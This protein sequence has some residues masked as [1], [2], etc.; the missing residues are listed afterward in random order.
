MDWE[1][2]RKWEI[3]EITV[4]VGSRRGRR[5]SRTE[6][7]GGNQGPRDRSLIKVVGKDEKS[8][9]TS[10][11][12]GVKKGEL[13]VCCS[14]SSTRFLSSHSARLFHGFII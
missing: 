8:T 11:I 10:K 3:M 1:A 14:F 13:S 12:E 2:G 7:R 6:V 5:R 4:H 9:Q